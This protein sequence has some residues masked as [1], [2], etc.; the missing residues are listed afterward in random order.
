MRGRGRCAD[1]VILG[2]AGEGAALGQAALARFGDGLRVPTSLAGR[3]ARPAAVAGELRIGGFGGAGGLAAY[4]AAHRVDLVIDAT[5]PF[6]AQISAQARA[7]CAAARVKRLRLERPPWPR[8]PRD[9][10][11]EGRHLAPPAAAPP[12]LRARAVLP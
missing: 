12:P 11:A 3:T 2:G 9:P 10:W 6:A 7:A 4:I 5:H 1:L 8:D